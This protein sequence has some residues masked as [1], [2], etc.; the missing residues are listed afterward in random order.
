MA[1]LVAAILAALLA[2]TL[3]IHLREKPP[4]QR[5]VRFQIP[6]LGNDRFEGWDTPVLSPD[7]TRIVFSSG[8]KLFVPVPHHPRSGAKY[9]RPSN[10]ERLDGENGLLLTPSIDHL[11]D[12]GFI[13]FADSGDLIVSPVAHRLSL[14]RMG[15]ETQRVVNVGG[16]TEG[17]RK[18][19][20]FHRNAVLL[21]V[22]R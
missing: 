6:P 19:L 17:Q 16:F 3:F 21:R 5:V 22:V 8:G 2:V 12:R 11:F 4:E 9:C 10:E 13:G 20:D 18:F 15:V 7:G 1:W 14:Q